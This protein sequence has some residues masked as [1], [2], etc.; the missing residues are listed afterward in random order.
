M[1]NR[2][3]LILINVINILISLIFIL[4][5]IQLNKID[6]QI[7][8]IISYIAIN[9]LISFDFLFIKGKL[10]SLKIGALLAFDI[11]ILIEQFSFDYIYFLIG[12][13]VIIA[14]VDFLFFIFLSE[15]LPYG[16][17]HNKSYNIVKI[18]A[19]VSFF[20]C[21]YISTKQYSPILFLVLAFVSLF[22]M[23]IGFYIFEF[24]FIK[25]QKEK[26]F[27][28]QKCVNIEPKEF[29]HKDTININLLNNSLYLLVNG[30]YEV[31]IRLFSQ[32]DD[33]REHER[34]YYFEVKIIILFLLYKDYKK[35]EAAI[36]D[37]LKYV[38]NIKNKKL[39]NFLLS[40]YGE[41]KKYVSILLLKKN[42]NL[43]CL[44]KNGYLNHCYNFFNY[45]SSKKENKNKVLL[46]IEKEIL[47]LN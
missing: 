20:L 37:E 15:T 8:G 43:C 25:N 7:Y 29:Y 27:N 26:I 14:A 30:R 12:V 28:G 22:I 23:V 44:K 2:N 11:I 5:S 38:R 10:P 33:V 32:I 1:K 35:I 46:P 36:N 16:I 4:V 13:Y 41:Y 31:G 34:L 17:F 18:I 21:L 9:A 24:I 19:F 47:N 45:V 39:K 42:V 3:I 6:R 40:L